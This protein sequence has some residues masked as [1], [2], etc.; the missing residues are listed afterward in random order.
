MAAIARVVA[1]DTPD[2]IGVVS[3]RAKFERRPRER[4][5]LQRLDRSNRSWVRQIS[6]QVWTWTTKMPVCPGIA[7][8]RC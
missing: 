4:S 6:R 2:L 7:G 8:G 5:P 1:A 3:E